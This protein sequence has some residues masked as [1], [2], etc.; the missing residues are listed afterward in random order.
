MAS[1]HRIGSLAN[2]SSTSRLTTYSNLAEINGLG[3]ELGH[4][5]PTLLITNQMKTP[6]RILV[7]RY[8]RRMVIENAIADAIDFFYMD[9]LSA[10]VPLKVQ[11]DL[12]TTLMASA[13]YRIL[14]KR[15]GNGMESAKAR[16][17]FRKTVNA[18]AIIES[19]PTKSL[20][21]WEGAP[22]TPSCSP[23]DTPIKDR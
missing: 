17:V 5:R 15:L 13:L 10:A 4:E 14:A 11:L 8:A 9:A 21:H 18:C 19:R 6:A 16:T 1:A 23:R 22:A 2:S 12:Q 20:S 7:D 3:V